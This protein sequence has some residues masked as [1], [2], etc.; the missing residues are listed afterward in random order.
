MR[1]S[2][3]TADESFRRQRRAA[4]AAHPTQIGIDHVT[5]SPAAESDCRELTLHMV[6]AAASSNKHSVLGDVAT[7]NVTVISL[8]DGGARLQV[9]KV[10]HPGS[11][12]ARLLITVGAGSGDPGLLQSPCCQL[13]LT[14]VA[15]LD[16]IFSQVRFSFALDT[17]LPFES[18]QLLPAAPVAASPPAISYLARDFASFRELILERLTVLMPEW[19]ERS[20]ADGMVTVAEA[21]ADAAD[22]LSY[23]QDAAA[24]EAYLGTARR[25]ISVRRHA[26]LLG[27]QMH[28]GCNARTWVQVQV[29]GTAP[30]PKGTRLLTEVGGRPLLVPESE[31]PQV[32]VEGALVFET[33]HEASLF[34]EHNELTFYTWGAGELTLPVGATRATL[35]GAL[36][37]L[38]AG[39]VLVLAAR[40]DPHTGRQDDADPELCHAVRLRRVTVTEDALGDQLDGSATEITEI[41]WYEE[42]ALPFAL[43]ISTRIDGQ[44]FA[45]SV[46]LGNL[47]LADHGQSIAEERLAPVEQ[48]AGR[49]YRPRLARRNLTHRVP[50]DHATACRRGAGRALVQDPGQALPAL[51]LTG[52][53]GDWRLHGDLLAGNRMTRGCVVEMEGDGSARLRFGDGICGRAP[54][55]GSV[56]NAS[57]RVGN[58]SIGNLGRHSLGHVVVREATPPIIGV[59]NPLPATGGCD[60][61]PLQQVRL[62]APLCLSDSDSGSPTSRLT[63]LALSH[64]QVELAATSMRWTGSWYTLVVG[65][66]LYGGGSLDQTIIAELA[67]LLEDSRMAGWE[68]EIAP[69][70]LVGL[71]IAMTVTAAPTCVAATVEQELLETFSDRE[72][73]DGRRGFFHPAKLGLGEPVYLSRV[74]ATTLAVPGVV[75]VDYDDQPP[76]PNRFRRFGQPARGEV[77]A[78]R[79][80]MRRLELPRVRNHP[81]LPEQGRIRFFMQ[82][83]R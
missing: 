9:L 22:Q 76:K 26:R 33:L 77:A 68:L 27:Y 66:K 41:E 7:G 83:G 56:L 50:Y 59:G 20:P 75:A 36:P 64:P 16:P 57:Y 62:S 51:T 70:Q 35:A 67:A 6:P 58:G 3:A 31:L 65:V 52:D 23:F 79:I 74:I 25:R 40:I 55:A 53:G 12:G 2:G 61:E 34:A 47:V 8:S 38:A 54:A 60:P 71:D 10:E 11:G 18:D 13:E 24:T 39:D 48:S 4:L 30:L 5:V 28:E 42:D 69:L 21:I 45:A 46:A 80:R 17:P 37:K 32:L 15:N 82:A 78:G 49:R 73:G 72:L 44:P 1:T 19:R 81:Q 63:S 43:T 29:S 14:G